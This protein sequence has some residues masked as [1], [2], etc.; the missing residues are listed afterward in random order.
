M[1]IFEFFDNAIAGREDPGH[2]NSIA[3]LSN[4]RQTRLT[5]EQINRLRMMNDVKKV[6]H[7]Q[8]LQRVSKQYNSTPDAAAAGAATV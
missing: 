7:E 6:E 2:D 3:K 8:Q 4:S 1:H 5:L